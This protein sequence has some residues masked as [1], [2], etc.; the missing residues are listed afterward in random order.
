MDRKPDAA[1]SE[2]PDGKIKVKKWPSEVILSPTQVFNEKAFFYWTHK[3]K[4]S[5]FWG[6]A[7]VSM[8]LA[9]MLFPLWP[10]L[11]KIAVFYISL[12]LLI[13]LVK[14]SANQVG[15]DPDQT[16]SLHGSKNHRV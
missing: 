8:V 16:P 2:S 12:Y 9:I 3:E 5:S 15:H 1:N 4:T 13:F 7:I 6:W 14:F 11:G 10:M